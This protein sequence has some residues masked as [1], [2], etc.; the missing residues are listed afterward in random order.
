MPKGSVN[1]HTERQ[2][3]S[4]LFR[5]CYVMFLPSSPS[6]LLPA[7]AATSRWVLPDGLTAFLASLACRAA[8]GGEF[9]TRI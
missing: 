5:D 3:P 6:A 8:A 4:A 7:N 1:S 9:S 2:A